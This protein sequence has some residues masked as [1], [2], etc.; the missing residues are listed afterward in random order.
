MG[1]QS[2][3][4]MPDSKTLGILLAGGLGRRMGVA[5]KFLMEYEGRP[6]LQHAIDRANPQVDQL[7]IS[8]NGDLSRLQ[9][10]ALHTIEDV[11]PNHTGPLAGIISAMTW[12]QKEV[13]PFDWFAV[14]ATDTPRFPHNCVERMHRTA[15]NSNAQ[16]VYCRSGGT[17]HYAFSLWSIQTLP[18]LRDIYRSGQR[19]L[20]VAIEGLR[21]TSVT[22]GEEDG[23]PFYN[24]N[25]P[26]DW[27]GLP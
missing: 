24:V 2:M 16:V 17:N 3:K 22:F 8:A 5:D 26:E 14:F 9:R 25:S 20:Y 7:I 6:L 15:M 10:F 1:H 18:M 23:D 13:L 27:Q 19:A 21:S 4:Q 11:F 12:A